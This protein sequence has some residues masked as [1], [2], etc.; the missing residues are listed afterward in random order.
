M[1]ELEKKF[2]LLFEKLR[3][4]NTV[5]LVRKTVKPVPIKKELPED[6]LKELARQ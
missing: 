1:D 3:V 5:D 2:G 4:E 6:L